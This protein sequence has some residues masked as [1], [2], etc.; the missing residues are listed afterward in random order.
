MR[1]TGK[2]LV[3]A[4]TLALLSAC[5]YLTPYKIEIQQG[6]VV[7]DD[8]LA[9]LRAGMSKQQVTQTIGTPLVTDVFHADRWDYVHYVR[10]RG[11]ML[12][13]RKLTLVFRED[14]L[15]K[16]EGDGAPALPASESEPAAGEPP[17]T[18]PTPSAGPGGEPSA[19]SGG[20]E[21]KP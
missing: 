2:S 7:K 12:E 9:Q 19:P 14:R 10:K 17:A 15:A 6:N 4:L 5:T 16:L 1:L 11:R 18:E 3:I 13:Q 20:E 8:E 21:R